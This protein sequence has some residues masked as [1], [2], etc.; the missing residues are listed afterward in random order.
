MKRLAISGLGD[1]FHSFRVYPHWVKM[2]LLLHWQYRFDTVINSFGSLFWFLGT[3]LT[4]GIVYGQVDSLAG[5]DRSQMLILYGVYNLWWGLMVTFFNGGLAIGYRIRHGGLDKILLWPGR[6]FFYAAIKFEPEFIVHCLVGLFLFL[7]ACWYSGV[8]LFLSNVLLFAVL[9]L[10]GLLLAFF[11]SIIFGATA[12]WLIENQ[13]LTS[14]FWVF[15]T[16]S[17]YPTKFF[18]INRALYYLVFTICPVVFMVAVPTEALLGQLG[19]YWLGISLLVLV[20]FA[21]LSRLVWRLGLRR[22]TGV[23]I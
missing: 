9:L 23:S 15:E 10:V 21:Y 2:R 7:G 3:L 14:F 22:Y 17:K 11:V 6:S 13:E 8:S 16:M 18:S 1:W 19:W 5:W 20:V 12:F 4:L